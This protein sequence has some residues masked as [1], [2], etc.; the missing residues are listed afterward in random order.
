M[1]TSFKFACELSH[2][3]SPNCRLQTIAYLNPPASCLSP[4]LKST[5]KNL[6]ETEVF[7]AVRWGFAEVKL[8][9]KTAIRPR[10]NREKWS[11][12]SIKGILHLLKGEC[13]QETCLRPFAKVRSYG[14]LAN[15]EPIQANQ[16]KHP[17]RAFCHHTQAK[18]AIAETHMISIL[19]NAFYTHFLYFK[20]IYTK[21]IGVAELVFVLFSFFF[22]YAIYLHIE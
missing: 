17:L 20:L 16:P 13:C 18:E 3:N 15:H 22:R 21:I 7:N 12:T 14:G 5:G 1:Q 9:I 2:L 11:H 4:R 8:Q 6:G 19:C 10:Q